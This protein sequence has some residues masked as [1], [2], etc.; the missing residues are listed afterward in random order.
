M[1]KRA[2]SSSCAYATS[3][4]SALAPFDIWPLS[5]FDT[6][7]E[8]LD[9]LGQGKFGEVFK[10]KKRKNREEVRVSSAMIS[11]KNYQGSEGPEM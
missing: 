8:K 3:T 9:K 10:V 1:N 11:K 6:Q 5:H 4:V 7:Y 2:T